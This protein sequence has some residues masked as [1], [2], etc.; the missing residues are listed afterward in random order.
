MCPTFT[1]TTA[2]GATVS[3]ESGAKE[4]NAP[5]FTWKTSLP[6]S[7]KQVKTST[8]SPKMQKINKTIKFLIM[9]ITWWTQLL[10]LT[11]KLHVHEMDPLAETGRDFQTQ[12]RQGLCP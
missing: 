4:R 9:K 6:A 10:A 1:H 8:T 11:A 7:V 5:R 3:V 2:R 12:D